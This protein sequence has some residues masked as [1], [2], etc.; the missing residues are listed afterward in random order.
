[1]DHNTKEQIKKNMALIACISSF[2]CLE[3]GYEAILKTKRFGRDLFTCIAAEPWRCR[4]AIHY[5]YTYFCLCPLFVRIAQDIKKDSMVELEGLPG[6][7]K[8]KAI[9]Q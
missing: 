4:H 5:G 8:M 3:H 2:N 9:N 1:M 6:K 7:D